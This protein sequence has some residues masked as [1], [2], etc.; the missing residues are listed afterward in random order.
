MPT[1]LES[2]GSVLVVVASPDES[3][4]DSVLVVLK[5][6]RVAIGKL[7]LL[8][9]FGDETHTVDARDDGHLTLT[10][11]A[12][13]FLRTCYDNSSSWRVVAD[14]LDINSASIW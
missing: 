6:D 3:V 7:H 9:A 2:Q 5:G 1:V 11:E 4:L 14:L 12:V 8:E 10:R 13:D